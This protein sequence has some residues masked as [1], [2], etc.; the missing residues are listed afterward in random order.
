MSWSEYY[1]EV[2]IWK[3]SYWRSKIGQPSH[4]ICCVSFFLSFFLYFF[5]Y[6]FRIQN[7]VPLSSSCLWDGIKCGRGFFSFS[8]F[9]FFSILFFFFFRFCPLVQDP[10]IYPS[11]FFLPMTWDSNLTKLGAAYNFVSQG[12]L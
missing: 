7:Y 6:W 1:V 11:I 8:L 5:V 3:I 4:F 9:F 12:W 2:C 10:K